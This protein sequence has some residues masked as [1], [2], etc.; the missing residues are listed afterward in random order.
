MGDQGSDS[1][2][3][4]AG[5]EINFRDEDGETP[6]HYTAEHNENPAVIAV[7]L[8]AGADASVRDAY[9]RRPADHANR[10]IRES[11]VYRDLDRL[12]PRDCPRWNTLEYFRFATEP[13]VAACLSAGADIN[14]WDKS[15]RTPLHCAAGH[16]ENPAVI[17]ALLAAGADINARDRNPA[18]IEVLI[19][20]GADLN[21]RG[22][23]G[24]TALHYAAAHNENPAVIEALLAAG[25]DPSVRN[26]DGKRPG[27]LAS[28]NE[29]IQ[30]AGVYRKLRAARSP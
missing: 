28:E 8:P 27:D 5:A 10:A 24:D 15:G 1:Q 12:G 2:G 13:E 16:S 17:E 26:S 9:G 22:D 3:L 25:A 4:S 30:G 29:A 20:A 23:D 6:L 19:A 18:V 11:D 7:L 14:A 21:A